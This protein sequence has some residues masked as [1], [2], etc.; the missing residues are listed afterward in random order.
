M[1]DSVYLT[2]LAAVKDRI[3]A[4]NIAGVKQ[5]K[6]VTVK[7]WTPDVIECLPGMPGVVIGPPDRAN[8]TDVGGTNI[9]D[10]IGYPVQIV[11]FSEECE[12]DNEETVRYDRNMLIH[13]RLR[14]GLIH[15]ALPNTTVYTSRLESEQIIDPYMWKQRNLFMGILVVRFISR[16]TRIPG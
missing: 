11:F 4:L 2:I 9:H 15:R 10:D 7:V 14:R 8:I 12:T 13:E 5:Q 16:E 3:A 1:A 6:V